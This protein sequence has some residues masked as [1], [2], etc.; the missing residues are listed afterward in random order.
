M[1]IYFQHKNQ[2]TKLV[3]KKN[4]TK[5]KNYCNIFYCPT[6]KHITKN[7]WQKRTNGYDIG[8]HPTIFIFPKF[9]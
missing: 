5:E 4:K 3:F 1:K 9:T 8:I 7:L 6:Q 2:T